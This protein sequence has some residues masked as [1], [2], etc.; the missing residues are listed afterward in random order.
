MRWLFAV[1]LV[2]LIGFGGLGL[3]QLFDGSKPTFERASRAAPTM[4]F[5]SL[6]GPPIN[7]AEAATDKPI[8]VNLWASWCTPCVAEHPLLV[9][10]GAKHPGQLWGVVYDD[11][12]ENARDFLARLGNPFHRI[13]HDPSG[14][15][16]LEFGLTGVPET[17]V[18]TPDGEIIYHLRGQLTYDDVQGL[19][20]AL[21]SGG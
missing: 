1:P 17:F 18:I 10:L 19:E 3:V 13:A 21:G 15:G 6:D 4:E 12:E 9:E 8:I 14:Q 7:F 11:T 5:A 2:L 16:G 20:A